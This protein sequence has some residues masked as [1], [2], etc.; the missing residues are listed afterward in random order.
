MGRSLQRDS[1]TV[2]S[3]S[4]PSAGGDLPREASPESPEA[5]P[6]PR[7]LGQDPRSSPQQKGT[8]PGKSQRGSKTEEGALATGA[9]IHVESSKSTAADAQ[10]GGATRGVVTETTVDPIEVPQGGGSAAKQASPISVK[11]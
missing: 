7:E 11:T 6:I 5:A 1:P 10:A 4:S 9:Q 3:S 2:S 8:D